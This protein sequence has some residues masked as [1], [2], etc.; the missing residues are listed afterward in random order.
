MKK[1][2]A[3]FVG[4][5][6]LTLFMTTQV[7]ATEVSDETQTMA[8]QDVF[9]EV[10]GV[11]TTF[12]NLS[13][14]VNTVTVD[15]ETK[16]VL[17][18]ENGVIITD[19]WYYYVDDT[20]VFGAGTGWYYAAD[21]FLLTDGIYTINGHYYYFESD[22]TMQTG[23][24]EIYDWDNQEYEYLLANT[25][26]AIITSPGWH[27]IGTDWH[28]VG[29]DGNLY[30]EGIY[31]IGGY[32]YIFK[33]AAMQVGFVSMR[34]ASSYKMIYVLTTSDGVIIDNKTGWYQQNNEWYYF[35]SKGVLAQDEQLTIGGV[36][37]Y[38]SKEATMETGYVNA[39]FTCY[40][41]DSN[42]A[43]IKNRWI[44]YGS[45]W[46]YAF[47]DGKLALDTWLISDATYA[48]DSCGVMITGYHW[49]NDKL[50]R[51]ADNGMLIA[52]LGAF[53][54]WKQVDGLWYYFK[55]KGVEYTGWVDNTYY[56][57]NSIMQYQTV[58]EVNDKSYY[59]DKNGKKVIGWY[60]YDG[61]WIY[62]KSDGV[63]ASDEW[64]MIGNKWYYFTDSGNMV[65]GMQEIY[66]YQTGKFELHHFDEDGSWK[67]QVTEKNKWVPYD[68]WW[69]YID[70]N[71]EFFHTGNKIINGQNYFF[72]VGIMI[73]DVVIDVDYYI[74]KNGVRATLPMGW[75]EIRE[76]W[77]YVDKNGKFV[78]GLQTIN[79]KKYYFS[80]RANMETG[81]IWM[82]EY[83]KYGLFGNDGA[84]IV[85]TTGW[86]HIK[87]DWLYFKNGQHL[88]GFHKIDGVTY[89][90]E[91]GYM[92]TG[93][94]NIDGSKFIYVF[95][96]NGNLA[97][98]KWVFFDN[99]WY[100]A[101]AE[102]R[103]LIGQH[104]IGGVTYT[105]D[106]YGAMI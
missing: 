89:Y 85:P 17:V 92:S 87:G 41:T 74:D 6:G 14:G 68:E 4:M 15:G 105:F 79:G 82:E 55:K 63:L 27:Q 1:G 11:E 7:F 90:F 10:E 40:I 103:A 20:I 64:L 99:K 13:P 35:K 69:M 66:N 75:H 84:M 48:M 36:S 16:K 95:S 60:Q 18:D 77:Y 83:S 9:G 30:V 28:Y 96:V 72:L 62:G 31:T 102:G 86:Y 33:E 50:Y 100:Y 52:E 76:E 49:I 53:S 22:G 54:G 91:N 42:G 2:L 32:K 78:T 12:E 29:T 88:D 73:N 104:I 23:L 71:G 47:E 58:V 24:I 34:D 98:N 43:I 38:F 39:G 101:D 57:S 97:K 106:I 70:E 21:G 65:T 94:C 5:I 56:V 59:L 8:A 19:G 67:G 44:Q 37:Y 51:F 61:N 3:M 81:Y 93:P 25:S 26:G 46:Y 80:S 45:E